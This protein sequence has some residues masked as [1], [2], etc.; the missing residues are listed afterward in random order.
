LTKSLIPFFI[1]PVKGEK[2]FPLGSEALLKPKEK[3][4]E[5]NKKH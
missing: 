1:L 2:S 3:A 4:G 5:E